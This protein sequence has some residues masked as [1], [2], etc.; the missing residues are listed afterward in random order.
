MGCNKVKVWTDS[1]KMLVKFMAIAAVPKD[2]IAKYFKVSKST[3]LEVCSE[4]L[5]EATD[6]INAN[7]VGALYKNAMKGNVSAQIFW[8]KTRL[9]WKE[10]SAVEHSGIEVVLGV[11]EKTN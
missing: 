6:G 10:T 7:V 1:E 8:C 4:E 11:K 9:G 5:N 3:L 2:R